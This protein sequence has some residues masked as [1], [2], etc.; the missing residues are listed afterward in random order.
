[1][2]LR[3]V[4]TG[5]AVA[6]LALFA[7][8]G[9][10]GAEEGQAEISDE[11]EECIEILDGGGEVD[12]CQKSPSLILPATNEIIWGSISFAAI[13]FLLYKFAW[14]GLK[15]GLDARSERI[16]D[17]LEEAERART[18]AATVLEEY[19]VQLADARHESSRIIDEARQ[20]ADALRRDLQTK[21]EAD[22]AE[23]RQRGAA[24]VESAKAQA[25]QDLKAEVASIAVGATEMLVKRNLDRD[26]QTQLVEDYINQVSSRN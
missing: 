15:K 1:M 11:A 12:D 20:T 2:R 17:D 21:A 24:D 8:A 22:I 25:M 23:L 13:V 10:A 19:K 16:R 14:P 6:L 4:M 7:A 3:P 5:V 18:E 26:T 9:P